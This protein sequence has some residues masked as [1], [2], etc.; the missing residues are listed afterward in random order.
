[1]AAS[2][3]L[4]IDKADE[5]LRLNSH[6]CHTPTVASFGK[7]LS[8]EV[9]AIADDNIDEGLTFGSLASL[10][11]NVDVSLSEPITPTFE[12]VRSH[13]RTAIKTYL[14]KCLGAVTFYTLVSSRLLLTMI[15]LAAVGY[16]LTVNTNFPYKRWEKISARSSLQ[17]KNWP[18]NVR[19]G[20][21]LSQLR[22]DEV[23]ALWEAT[24]LTDVSA[25]VTIVK[26]QS[27]ATN[28]SPDGTATFPAYVHTCALVDY[29][30]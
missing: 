4:V 29:L 15:L 6:Y 21:S 19:F 20:P 23:E 12:A 22:G 26:V 11:N 10:F 16:P 1:M 28:T 2:S 24:T 5:L 8:R 27:H 13:R 7:A 17:I 3:Q 30:L 25:R 9:R 18:A 14:L